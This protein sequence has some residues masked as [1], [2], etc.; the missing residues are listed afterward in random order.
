MADEMSMALAELLSKINLE[1]DFL[2]EGVRLLAQ[3]LMELEVTQKV[4]AGRHWRRTHRC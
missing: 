2:R 1:P 4:G 3:A